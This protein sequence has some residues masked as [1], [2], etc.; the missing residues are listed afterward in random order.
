MPANYQVP[1]LPTLLA[2]APV[3][4]NTED[5]TLGVSNFGKVQSNTGA[6]GIV[7]LT[8]PSAASVAGLVVRLQITEGQPLKAVPASGEK[9]YLAG[10]GAAS[11]YLLI[12]GSLGSFAEL[13]SDGVVYHVTKCNGVLT[14]EA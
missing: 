9:I 11:K 7:A 13:I 3:E 8:L 14:K 10:S 6:T 12:A 2:T 5:A 4:A 1:S